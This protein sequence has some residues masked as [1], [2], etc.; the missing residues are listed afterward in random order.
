MGLCLLGF[1]L[2]A[3]LVRRVTPWP[4]EYGLQAKYEYLAEHREEF[5][6]LFIGSSSTFYGLIPPSFDA[7]TAQAGTVTR[8]F[9]FGVGGMTALESDYVLQQ[10]LKL[11]MPKLR[12]VFVESEYDWEGRIWDW[13]N[14]FSPRAVHWHSFEH[15]ALAVGALLDA[16]VGPAQK[17]PLWRWK[18]VGVHL[19]LA[20][21][22]LVGLGQ[23]PRIFAAWSGR[24]AHLVEPRPA[25]LDALRGYVDLDQIRTP[26]AQSAREDFL[27]SASD[28]L[29]RVAQ[30]DAGNAAAVAIDGHPSSAGIRAQVTAIREHGAEALFY[31]GPRDFARPASYRL[32]EAGVIPILFGFNQPSRYPELYEI[33]NHFDRSH[34]DREGAELYTR[35][36]AEAFVEH[37]RTQ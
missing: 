12:R 34:L 24:D 35:L 7:F 26:E 17:D 14:R 27:A 25:E 5:D 4:H 28:Y 16:E 2:A 29:E 8:S 3:S 11:G 19:Q 15:T 21:R 30:L 22:K 23:G 10:V 6:T 32:A 36:L 9:N 13:R 33:E 20:G 18:E 37:L 31:I 1:A